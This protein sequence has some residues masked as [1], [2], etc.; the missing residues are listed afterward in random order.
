MA[1]QPFPAA[2]EAETPRTLGAVLLGAARGWDRFW[3]RPAD[4]TTLG[5]IRIC[6][7]LVILYVH[8]VYTFDLQQLFGQHAWID[9]RAI[10]E[11]RKNMPIGVLPETFNSG[12]REQ[13]PPPKTKAERE[14]IEAVSYTHLTLPTTERV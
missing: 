5:L 10:N 13:P 11:L 12:P 9:T 2:P 6:A 7:G 3:F 14:Y 1:T 8:L 4:P